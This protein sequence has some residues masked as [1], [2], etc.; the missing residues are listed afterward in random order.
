LLVGGPVGGVGAIEKT[1]VDDGGGGAFGIGVGG[2][3]VGGAGV[4]RI[5]LAVNIR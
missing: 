3:G 2:T 4:G 1:V 5:G